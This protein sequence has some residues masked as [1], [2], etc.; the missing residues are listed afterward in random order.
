MADRFLHRVADV[1]DQAAGHDD[2]KHRGRGQV[3]GL[4][5]WRH[6]R[7]EDNVKE[8]HPGSLFST[9]SHNLVRADLHK[10]CGEINK[11]VAEENREHWSLDFEPPELIGLVG[12]KQEGDGIIAK[13]N[14]LPK[15]E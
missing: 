13:G 9:E 2:A 12:G 10:D 5:R 7:E 1:Q 11:S 8:V 4:Q 6:G 15:R 3:D 14:T